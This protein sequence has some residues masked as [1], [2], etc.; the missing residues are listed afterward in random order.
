MHL[1]YYRCIFN[2]TIL[3]IKPVKIK[4][5]FIAISVILISCSEL[6]LV[7]IYNKVTEPYRAK[8]YDNNYSSTDTNIIVKIIDLETG[9][10]LINV[11]V[12]LTLPNFDTMSVISDRSGCANF[13]FP[14]VAEGNY[15]VNCLVSMNDKS[16]IIHE[17]HYIYKKENLPIII[18]ASARK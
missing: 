15:T 1:F 8:E 18:Y 12:R 14:K 4:Y 10:P 6:N 2:I 3:R 11:K 5:L 17:N 13:I 16:Y 7:E 9:K